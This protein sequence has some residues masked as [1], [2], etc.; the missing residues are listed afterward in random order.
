MEILMTNSSDFLYPGRA[1]IMRRYY[2][3]VA[4]IDA[5]LSVL[6]T[7]F[8]AGPAGWNRGIQVQQAYFL[9]SF[10]PV[11]ATWSIESVRKR[12]GWALISL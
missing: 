10:F 1:T 7:A 11:I 5:L 12:T 4:A 3:G 2:T 9:I 6:V 8:I